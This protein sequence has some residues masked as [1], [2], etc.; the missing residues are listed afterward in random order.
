VTIGFN[1]SGSGSD[2]PAAFQ[3]NGATC[4]RSLVCQE[5]TLP[6]VGEETLVALRGPAALA[7]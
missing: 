1:G 3:L 5:Q 7:Y 2:P 4:T 6:G